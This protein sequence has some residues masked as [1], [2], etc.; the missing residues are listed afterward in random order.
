MNPS[1]KDLL[2]AVESAPAGQVVLLPNNGN[3]ILTA[4]QVPELTK[5]RV[6]VVPARNLPQGIAAVLA[7]DLTTPLDENARAMTAATEHVQAIEVTHAMRDASVDGLDIRRGDIIGLLNDKIVAAGRSVRDVVMQV[8]AELDLRR[9]AT[10][11]IYSGAEVN[12]KDAE[13]LA[14]ELR[15]RHPDLEVDL[16][17]GRQAHYPYVIAVE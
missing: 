8:L 2:Q 12:R 15:R 4:Q 3:V 13:A 1:I 9:F 10:L 6:V 14:A 5:K 17:E 16:H 7:F 11:T